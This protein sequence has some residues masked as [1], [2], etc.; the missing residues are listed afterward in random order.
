MTNS[1]NHRQA[2]RSPER[3]GLVEPSDLGVG[4]LQFARAGIVG[5]MGSTRRLRY[6][7]DRTPPREEGKRHLPRRRAMR[8]GDLLQDPP[9]GRRRAREVAVPERAVGNDRHG[10]LLA[11][12][13]DRV[14]YGAL[15]QMVEHLVAGD[16]ALPDYA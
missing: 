10:V 6:G 13:D 4:E 1:L 5:G 12:G 15:L 11:P 2:F 9:A 7:E 8:G 3:K 14:F 16:P